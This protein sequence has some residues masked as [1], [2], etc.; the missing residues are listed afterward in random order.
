MDK[1]GS[2]ELYLI[3]ISEKYKKPTLQLYYEGYFNNF[4]FHWKSIYLLP[5]M[6][7]VDTKSRVFQYKILNNILFVNKML[8]KLRKVELP[9]CSFCKAEDETYMYLFYRCRKTSI[10]WRQLQEFYFSTGLDLTGISPQ[11]ATVGFLDDALEHIVHLNHVLLI[12]KNYLYKARENK[13]LNFNIP[14]NYL[15]KIRDL[16]ANLKDN[17][18]YNKNWTVISSML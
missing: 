12:F 4:H 6:V 2:K 11:S 18:K 1:L 16:E 5:R 8:F 10:L 7:T 3:Q 9:L 15:T 14:K 17:D 13:N